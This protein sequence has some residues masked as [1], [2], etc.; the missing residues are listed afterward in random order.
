M[1]RFFT[2]LVFFGS[3]L[4]LSMFGQAP[5]GFQFQAV[6]RDMAGQPIINQNL[7]VRISISDEE[8]GSIIIYREIHYTM[9]NGHGLITVVI[10]R[11]DVD[12]GDFNEI[13]W[14]HGVKFLHTEFDPELSGT[15]QL[16]G[17][18][19]LLSVPY[20]LYAERSGNML[21]A[22]DGITLS[23]D[24]VHNTSPSLWSKGSSD[25]VYYSEGEV[26]IG[27]SNP[28][29]MFHV[30]A[31]DDAGTFPLSGFA[32]LG[33]GNTETLNG[34]NTNLV[35]GRSSA[36]AGTMWMQAFHSGSSPDQ[37][38]RLSLNPSIGN[39]GIG[40]YEPRTKFHVSGGDLYVENSNRGIILRSPGGICYRI[41]VDNN[42]QLTSQP[43]SCP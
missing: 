35:I 13:D 24:T 29:R 21:T 15:Y 20:A 40:T 3:A 6:L 23:G 39:V 9:T 32:I 10:G 5:S 2:A 28:A 36:K 1:K 25:Q 43:V 27:T 14:S 33:G 16:L 31:G 30:D 38:W 12:L 11:G 34:L 41:Q 19:Q 7:N 18:Q 22:G 26:G 37:S 42:G 8:M 4:W 17:S